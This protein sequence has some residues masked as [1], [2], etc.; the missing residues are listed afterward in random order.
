MKYS[1]NALFS[2][3]Y[4]IFGNLRNRES[5]KIRYLGYLF[6]TKHCNEDFQ[7]EKHIIFYQKVLKIK[8]QSQKNNS[9]KIGNLLYTYIECILRFVTFWWP[10]NWWKIGFWGQIGWKVTNRVSLESEILESDSECIEGAPYFGIS[11]I[12]NRTT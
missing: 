11:E 3:F 6:C 7:D 9:M 5:Y 12:Q 2:F 4:F 8:D 10:K 1:E